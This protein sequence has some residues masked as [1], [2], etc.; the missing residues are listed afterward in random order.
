[1]ADKYIPAL[2]YDWL[3]RVYDP[4]V[5]LTTREI[6]FKRALIDQAD[7]HAGQ[8]VLD[9][10]C[11]T[12]TL[13]VLV[14]RKCPLTEVL[15]IDGDPKILAIARRKAEQNRVEIDFEEG[16]SS[17]LPYADQSLDR[18]LSSLFFHHLTRRNKLITLREAFRVLKPEGEVHIADWGSPANFLMKIAS[19]GIRMLDGAETTDDNFSGLLPS[20]VTETGFHG[21]ETPTHFNSLFGTIRLIKAKK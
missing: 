4:L 6:T 15:G 7:I 2:G 17:E 14:K 5:R 11:G 21:T 19:Q 8:R 12:G 20:L 3:T 18:V 16:M 1:M 9:L 10:A 13:A